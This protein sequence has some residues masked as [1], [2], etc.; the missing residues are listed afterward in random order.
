MEARKEGEREGGRVWRIRGGTEEGINTKNSQ[1]VTEL[2]VLERLLTFAMLVV[3]V[4]KTR[5]SGGIIFKGR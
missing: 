4:E 5:E 3:K 2:T 1:T